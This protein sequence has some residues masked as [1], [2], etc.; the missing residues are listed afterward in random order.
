MKAFIIPFPFLAL[1]VFLPLSLNI[2][3]YAVSSSDDEEFI[4]VYGYTNSTITHGARKHPDKIDIKFKKGEKKHKY[5]II[6]KEVKDTIITAGKARK[7]KAQTES[8]LLTL[9]RFLSL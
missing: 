7:E 4:E 9:I 1:A 6:S 5:S 3:V 8:P 2:T